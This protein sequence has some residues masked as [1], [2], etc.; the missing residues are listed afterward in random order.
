MIVHMHEGVEVL[1]EL[2]EVVNADLKFEYHRLANVITKV[3]LETIRRVTELVQSSL[4]GIWKSQRSDIE[5][6]D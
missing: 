4:L 2:K 3:V 5:M 1:Q 6:M